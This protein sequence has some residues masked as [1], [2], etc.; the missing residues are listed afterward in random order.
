MSLAALWAPTRAELDY[1]TARTQA[2]IDGGA[3]R[4]D[5]ERMAWLEERIQQAY[6]QRPG[7]DAELQRDAERELRDYEREAG[8]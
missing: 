6:L 1:A 3:S 7:A 2:A 5:V 8:Q 4:Y